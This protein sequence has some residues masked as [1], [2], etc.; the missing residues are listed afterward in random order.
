M[1]IIITKGKKSHKNNSSQDIQSPYV[2][3]YISVLK[4]EIDW[5][6]VTRIHYSGIWFSLTIYDLCLLTNNEII[7]ENTEMG[8]GLKVFYKCTFIQ[9]L[10]EYLGALGLRLIHSFI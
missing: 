1:K 2:S 4:G 5:V 7:E 9:V 10:F 3:L 6:M 8:L